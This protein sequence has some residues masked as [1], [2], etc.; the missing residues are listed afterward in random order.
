LIGRKAWTLVAISCVLGLSG[1]TGS[2]VV[3]EPTTQ[4][5]PV[6]NQVKSLCAASGLRAVSGTQALGLL[7]CAGSIEGAPR[8]TLTVR[9]GDTID[10][11]ADLNLFPAPVMNDD[12]PYVASVDGTLIRALRPGQV[13]IRSTNLQCMNG[14]HACPLLRVTVTR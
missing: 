13:T 10:V 4:R 8:P 11:Q 6:V 9:V 14:I 3:T 5:M 7:N 12:N 2:Q 1:C